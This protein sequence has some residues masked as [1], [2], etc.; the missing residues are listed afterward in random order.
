MAFGLGEITLNSYLGEELNAS[1]AINDTESAPD[2]SC[3]VVKDLTEDAVQRRV[4][5]NLVERNGRFQ[6]KLAT[7][8][9]LT[10]PI[11]NINV[12]YVCEPHVS[13]DY[14]LLLDP[15]PLSNTVLSNPPAIVNNTLESNTLPPSQS[16]PQ[17]KTK[18]K[19]TTRTPASIE[20]GDDNLTAEQ[21]T[22]DLTQQSSN[23][24]TTNNA[25]KPAPKKPKASTKPNTSSINDKLN[26][27]YV[28][29]TN[30]PSTSAVSIDNA[31]QQSS[32]SSN[33]SKP[34]LVISGGA[35][36]GGSPYESAQ[37]GLTLRLE[38]EIDFARAEQNPPVLSNEDAMD[39][40]TVMANRLA[41][42]E[43][44]IL[45][46]QTINTQLKTKLVEAENDGF[47]LSDSQLSFIRYALYA[48]AIL[49][50][51]MIV[52]FVRRE[53][54]KRKLERDEAIWFV[55]NEEPTLSD[56][57]LMPASKVS[58]AIFKSN[59]LDAADE[60]LTN[61][62]T[63]T[64]G[65]NNQT[66]PYA[67]SEQEAENVLD[68]AEVFIAHGR[69]N[70]AIQLLQNHLEEF[71]TES[72]NVWLRLLALLAGEDSE[73]EYER[74][75]TECNQFFNIKLPKYADALLD[76]ES[77][78]EEYP[79]IVQRLEGVW[80]SQFAVSFLNDLIYNQ[81]SQPREGFARNTFVELFFLRQVASI[82]AKDFP[83]DGTLEAYSPAALKPALQ[84]IAMNEALFDDA[85]SAPAESF[86][87]DFLE[88]SP[89]NESIVES[90]NESLY[91]SPAVTDATSDQI[92]SSSLS[93]QNNAPLFTQDETLSA[94]DDGL[95]IAS[96]NAEDYDEN[97][98]IF[99]TVDIAAPANVS[100]A[101]ALAI[102]MPEIASFEDDAS[103]ADAL[104]TRASFD[105]F[106]EIDYGL[107]TP[108]EDTPEE[109]TFSSVNESDVNNDNTLEFD[110]SGLEN[111]VVNTPDEADASTHPAVEDTGNLIEFD[112]DLTEKDEA[113]SNKTNPATAKKTK[114]A[115]PKKS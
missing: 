49:V 72:P 53:L 87:N 32:Q 2:I 102:E 44:Q 28:G 108:E 9:F 63:L 1:I 48:L 73:E 11:V 36:S 82:L 111:I 65:A 47:K 76:D 39:E 69:T 10:E 27:A 89:S 84:N 95:T 62:Q 83:V 3:F 115:T 40:V 52:A 60:V 23:L 97:D 93:N 74:A 75:V 38:T 34:Y 14:V 54:I 64:T 77:S 114:P 92:T 110:M 80:G 46:L 91:E 57:P 109:I 70:L 37:V 24:A 78:I 68:H 105:A 103:H 85:L 22:N 4:T 71:P 19:R 90:P 59:V 13:R 20:N 16:K 98:F 7:R 6:L 100:D 67:E 26:E 50:V 112:W 12:N 45:S 51:L 79:H 88:D 61:P 5:G 113:T 17:Q 56:E 107:E 18:P 66:N 30:T 29:S 25:Q 43:K 41:H 104:T 101:D 15:A 106:D 35:L 96:F 8:A 99:E 31:S 55:G 58:E 33:T 21:A 86:G 94:T 42:L 81:Q